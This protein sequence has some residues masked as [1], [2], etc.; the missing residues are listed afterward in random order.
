MKK[1]RTE[2]QIVRD[3]SKRL[4]IKPDK[5]LLKAAKGMDEMRAIIKRAKIHAFEDFME[6]RR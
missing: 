4:G 5:V 3:N 6:G 1:F 2:V